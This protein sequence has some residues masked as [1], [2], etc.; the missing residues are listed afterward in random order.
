MSPGRRCLFIDRYSNEGD[1][2]SLQVGD[3]TARAVGL[4]WNIE[5]KSAIAT[6]D[7]PGA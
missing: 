3:H 5:G 4:D 7:L 1:A 6:I 2:S